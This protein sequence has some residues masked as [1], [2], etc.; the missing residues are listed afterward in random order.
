[1]GD[2]LTFNERDR[3][4]QVK[5]VMPAARVVLNVWDALPNDVKSDIKAASGELCHA[6]HQLDAAMED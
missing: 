2:G 6:L 5:R 1:M 3:A 4:R